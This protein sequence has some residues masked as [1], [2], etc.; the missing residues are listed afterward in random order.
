VQFNFGPANANDVV[1]CAAQTIALPA[2]RYTTLLMLAA[3]V[4]GSQASQTFT[5]TYTDGTTAPIVQSLSDWVETTTYSNQFTAV[6]MP[7][8]DASG[9]GSDLSA[10]HVYGYLF[11]LNNTKT[12]RSLRLPNNGDVEVLALTLANTPLPVSL[13]SDFNR[14]GMY[15]DGA[16]FTSGAGLD[17]DG[18]AYSATLLG[19]TQSWHNSLFEFGLADET[20]VVSA[21]GQSVS[22][23]Q[24]QYSALLM[25][26]AAVN[27]SQT[28]QNF[29]VHYTNG[30]TSSLSPSMSDWAL[31]QHYSGESTV[32]AMGYRDSSGGSRDG[33]DVNLYGY[34]FA[35]N[36][37]YVVQS[38]TLPN[39]DNVEVLALTLSNF[40]A[41]LPEAPAIAIQPAGLTVTNGNPAA[42]TVKATGS[43]TLQYQW[44]LNATNLTDGGNVAGSSSAALT[45]SSAGANDAGSYDVIVSNS[46]G[47]VTSSVVTLNVVFF[48]ASAVQNG[49]AVTFGWQTTAGVSY[50]VQYTTDLSSSNWLNLGAPIVASNN[51]TTT[52][53]NLGPDPQRFYRIIQQ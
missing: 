29:V 10:S 12:V 32:V 8:R 33:T 23:P 49:D 5:L 41:A 47:S 35:L 14:G 43:P 24:G 37:N 1:K 34:S 40:T 13:Q 7:Y 15:T 4:E 50:Q 52:S 21:A 36:G 27:G 53:D 39:N 9:G 11:A 28:G 17:N 51:V 3:G 18:N 30:A 19:P 26:A 48:F 31:P 38:L 2:N 44:Q 46:Y 42:F 16:E 45:L 22:L 20:N 6:T 25:L